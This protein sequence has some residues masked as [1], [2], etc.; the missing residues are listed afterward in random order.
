MNKFKS[1]RV[2]NDPLNP[3]YNLSKVEMRPVTPPKFIR[4][5]MV[6]DDIEKAKPKENAQNKIKTREA[7]KTD[8]IDGTKSKPRHQARTNNA[9]YSAMNYDDVTKKVQKSM[10]CSNPLDPVYTIADENGKPC[11]IG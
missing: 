11:E 3:N 4:D 10:R 6:V 9:D 1:T 7:L 2:G 8:D 5:Q